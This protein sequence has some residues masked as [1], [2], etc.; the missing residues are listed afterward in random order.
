MR[1]IILGKQG[2]PEGKRDL[3]AARTM[4]PRI[5]DDYKRYGIVP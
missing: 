4:R 3:I 2:K 1:G 5:D